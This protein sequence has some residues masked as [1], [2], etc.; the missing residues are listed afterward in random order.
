MK[1]LFLASAFALA[2]TATSAKAEPVNYDFDKAH[3]SIE[4]YINHL[5]FSNFQGEFQGF[6]GTLVFDEANPENS[7]VEVSVDVASVD[8][9]VEALDTHLKSADFFDVAKFPAMTFKSKSIKVTGEN[10]GE[11]TGDFTLMGITK[12]LT[13]NTTLNK[14]GEHPIMKKQFV[15]FSATGT[16]KRSD[17]GITTYLPALGDEVT[18]RIETEAGVK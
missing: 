5:G 14:S 2:L 3:S 16:L 12:E 11:I 13:L 10:T 1:K 17:F 6:D 4:F 7:M 15:G 9:D 8:T 18:I